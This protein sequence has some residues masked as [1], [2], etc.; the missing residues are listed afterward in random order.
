MCI[1]DRPVSVELFAADGL[2]FQQDSGVAIAGSCT[3]KDPQK[4]GS[5]THLTLTTSDL[6]ENSVGA[7]SL[8][9]KTTIHTLATKTS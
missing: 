3:R 5:Y 1:R 2:V 8:K 7:G 4:P 9:K 6:G